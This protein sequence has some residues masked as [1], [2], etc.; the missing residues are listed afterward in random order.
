MFIRTLA[1]AISVFFAPLVAQANLI[2][3]R[4]NELIQSERESLK[5][6]VKKELRQYNVVFVSGFMNEITRGYFKT[7]RT[8][9]EKEVPGITISEIHPS[10]HTNVTKNVHW[11]KLKLV[12][13]WVDGGRKP[14]LIFAHSKGGVET[15]LFLLKNPH[16]ID[17]NIIH[18]AILIQAPLRGTP[19]ADIGSEFTRKYLR[20]WGGPDSM[21][22]DYIQPLFDREFAKF[23]RKRTDIDAIG[24]HVYYLRSSKERDFTNILI[25]ACHWSIK[26]F[27]PSDGVVVTRDQLID[28]FG[29]D[30]GIMHADH[31]DLFGFGKIVGEVVKNSSSLFMISTLEETLGY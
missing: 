28:G 30:L 9:L 27:G 10:S 21:R 2:T 22:S 5:P 24:S 15:L 17:K 3:Q 7:P 13:A 29:T 31:G 23:N 11:L 16:F 25:R 1:V 19:V 14:L 6:E 12:E 4:M 26:D 18:R 8:F 20:Y